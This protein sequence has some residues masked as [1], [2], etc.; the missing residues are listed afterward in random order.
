MSRPSHQEDAESLPTVDEG[1]EVPG[2]IAQ[3]HKDV[4]EADIYPT[5]SDEDQAIVPPD[6]RPRLSLIPMIVTPYDDAEMS[7]NTIPVKSP[8]M[9]ASSDVLDAHMGVYQADSISADTRRRSQWEAVALTISARRR[10]RDATSAPENARRVSWSPT[11]G[12]PGRRRAIEE[13]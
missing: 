13:Q 4:P 1:M 5:S 6:R 3:N 8:D 7:S 11:A 9:L 2:E 10:S 12:S